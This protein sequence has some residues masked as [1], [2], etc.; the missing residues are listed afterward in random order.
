MSILAVHPSKGV[1]R[2]E[3]KST[4]KYYV[5]TLAFPDGTVFYVGKGQGDRIKQHEWEARAPYSFTLKTR[6]IRSIWAEGGRVVKT[7]IYETDIEEDAL[8][9]EWILI[10]MV[11]DRTSLINERYGAGTIDWNHSPTKITSCSVLSPLKKLAND[12][13]PIQPVQK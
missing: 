3:N 12:V 1:E 8:C 13:G 6:V 5:Y 10:N 2:M 9:Y 7:K 11:Y 4:C